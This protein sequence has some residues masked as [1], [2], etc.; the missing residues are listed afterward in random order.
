M[1]RSFYFSLFTTLK[2]KNNLVG[3]II[4]I[5]VALAAL[6]LFVPPLTDFFEFNTLSANQLLVSLFAGSIS[7][8]WYEA[9]KWIKRIKA[10]KN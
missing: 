10:K 2:Y 1:N 5:T 6:L 3:L 4:G 9:V 8:L 7:V